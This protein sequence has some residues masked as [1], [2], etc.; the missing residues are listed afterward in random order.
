MNARVWLTGLCA[1]A[2]LSLAGCGDSGSN[3]NESSSSSSSAASTSSTASSQTSSTATSTSST[4]TSSSAGAQS[5]PNS[6][7]ASYL[8]A[9]GGL[10]ESLLELSNVAGG[11]AAASRSYESRED[12]SAYLCPQGGS[13]DYTGSTFTFDMCVGADG[14]VMDGSFSAGTDG[15]IVFSSFSIDDGES[16][17]Y[18]N[19][20][21]TLASAAEFSIDGTFEVT[22]GDEMI[23]I[24]FDDYTYMVSGNQF[25][26]NGGISI[27]AQPD[28]CGANGDYTITTTV[29]LTV[30]ANGYVSGTIEVAEGGNITVIVFNG[31]GTATI[32]GQTYDLSELEDT[33]AA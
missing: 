2:V 3:N 15:I 7:K 23:R 20:T 14:T 6:L 22:E 17:T 18:L 16:Y 4:G 11:S 13:A 12:F 33:C 29:P 28:L 8:M 25:T 30:N 10:S 5:T 21:M 19:A 31:D 32:N 27:Q 9:V 1:A 24:V 26:V